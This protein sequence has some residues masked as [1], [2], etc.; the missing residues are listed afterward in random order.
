VREN[1]IYVSNFG[2]CAELDPTGKV[3]RRFDLA[4]RS[5]DSLRVVALPGGRGSVL[6]TFN[7]WVPNIELKAFDRDGKV[8]WTY[9]AGYQ[10]VSTCDLD[11]DG[12][13]EVLVGYPSDSLRV[14]GPG[15]FARRGIGGLHVLGADGKLLWKTS[16]DLWAHRVSA[17][18]V[19]GEGRPQVILSVW[20]KEQ[21]HLFSGRGD[22]QRVLDGGIHAP[23]VCVIPAR[24][25][26]A[27]GTIVAGS[28]AFEEKNGKARGVTLAALDGEGVRKWTLALPIGNA[29]LPIGLF[30]CPAPDRPWLAVGTRGRVDVVDAEAGQVV[31]SL[32]TSAV[33]STP[34]AVSWAASPGH[35]SPLLLVA[36]IRDL[37]GYRVARTG[38]RH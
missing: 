33:G 5:G 17:G 24:E 3:V 16:P 25:S 9:P 19:S 30:V 18:D 29:L 21:I 38:P 12:S 13:E 15:Q 7:R 32:W 2:H 6:L 36:S 11:G 22:A 31:A 27:P 10:D 20:G 34:T 4:T 8:L 35:D 28:L 23:D 26:G 37:G 1:P 14:V